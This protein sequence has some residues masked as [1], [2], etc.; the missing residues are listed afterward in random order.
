MTGL[1]FDLR[2]LRTTKGV[3]PEERTKLHRSDDA[4]QKFG[5]PASEV[6]RGLDFRTASQIVETSG[7]G[8]TLDLYRRTDEAAERANELSA[9]LDR[10]GP[11][12]AAL[13]ASH[14]ALKIEHL[15]ALA[16][17][18]RSSRMMG[19][20]P[21]PVQRGD[22]SRALRVAVERAE[23]AIHRLESHGLIRRSVSSSTIPYFTVHL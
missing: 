5:G 4:R 22:L 14:P 20:R 15:E 18:Q 21:V 8:S 13:P 7:Y 19:G 17:I 23:E 3:T 16:T 11:T 2:R 9:R 10:L 6:A 12:I 1:N